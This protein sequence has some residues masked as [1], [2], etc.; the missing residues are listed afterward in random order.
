MTSI[1]IGAVLIV[2]GALLVL[3]VRTRIKNKN[4]E[5]QYMETKPLSDIKRTLEENEAAGLTNYREFAEIKG[6]ASSGSSVKAPY[7]ETDVAYY[8][9]ELYQVFEETQTYTDERGTHQ[10]TSRREDLMSSQ[11]SPGPIVVEDGGEKAYIEVLE[12]GMRLDTVKTLDKFEPINMMNQYGFFSS[13]HYSPRGTRTLGFRMVER[14]IPLKHPL[15]ILGDVYSQNGRL[16]ISKPIDSKKPFI[17]SVK[18]EADL[19]HSNKV[20]MTMSLVSGIICAAA[21]IA[22]MIFLH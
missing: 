10:R 22:I 11:K 6:I 8:Q 19:I 12:H 4:I 16:N 14:T 1:I 18:S 20:G 9:A 17:V 15:Y 3:V 5:I 13:F 7:S 2:V 21:G